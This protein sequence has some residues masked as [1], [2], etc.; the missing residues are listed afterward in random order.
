MREQTITAPIKKLFRTG[1]QGVSHK[2]PR[3]SQCISPRWNW[4]PP[5]SQRG[6][7]LHTR[8]RVKGRRSPMPTTGE[9]A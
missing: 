1:P 8:L 9:K 6:G 5:P 7:G 2:V 3:V 4:T